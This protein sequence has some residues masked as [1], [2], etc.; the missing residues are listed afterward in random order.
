MCFS[1]YIMVAFL[2]FRITAESDPCVSGTNPVTRVTNRAARAHKSQLEFLSLIRRTNRAGF[3]LD[4]IQ[5]YR[6]N[7]FLRLLYA[8]PKLTSANVY[9][10]IRNTIGNSSI[11]Y[12]V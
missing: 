6:R 1:A 12:F 9:E 7:N 8:M 3:L 4:A 10:P 5:G 2:A 11:L